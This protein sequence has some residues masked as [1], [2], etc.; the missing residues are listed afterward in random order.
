MADVLSLPQK[1]WE[2]PKM[3]VVAVQGPPLAVAAR[4]DRVTSSAMSSHPYAAILLA[5]VA[6][7][8]SYGRDKERVRHH[9]VPT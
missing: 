1:P 6:D 9:Q 2:K 3:M 8:V 4:H 7:Q 5:E